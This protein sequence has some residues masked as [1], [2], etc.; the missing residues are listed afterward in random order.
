MFALT[1]RFA[2]LWMY[3]LDH[4]PLAGPDGYSNGPGTGA[5]IAPP[6]LSGPDGKLSSNSHG[7]RAFG[8]FTSDY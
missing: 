3:G 8:A 4:D 1:R 6:S 5:V 2:E 7:G